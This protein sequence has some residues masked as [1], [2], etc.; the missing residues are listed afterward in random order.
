MLAGAKCSQILQLSNGRVQVL[1]GMA[2]IN[3][4]DG[5]AHGISGVMP[6]PA[7]VELYARIFELHKSGNPSGANELFYRMLPYLTFGVQHLELLLQMEKRVLVNRGVFRSSKM[8]EPTM[9]FDA[10][11]QSQI[12]DLTKLILDLCEEVNQAGKQIK[13]DVGN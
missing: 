2:G 7:F 3:L 1:Y 5:F 9:Q 10:E 12:N 4:L 13:R 11:Y 6:G 8:R